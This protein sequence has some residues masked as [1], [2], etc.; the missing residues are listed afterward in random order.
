MS[1]KHKKVSA[2]LN[3]IEL[4]LILASTITGCVSISAFSSLVG[5]PLGITISAIGLN[6]CAIAAENKKYKSIIKKKKKNH[7]KIVFLAKYK[8]NSIEVLI[9][10]ALID[11][12]ISHYEF[13]LIN[14]I[15]KEYNE[16]KDEIKSLKT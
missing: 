2:T 15:L 12:V 1:K 8:L 11:S 5:I 13:V 9:S 10:K 7:D 16:I 14:N 3:Y 4:F 6:I